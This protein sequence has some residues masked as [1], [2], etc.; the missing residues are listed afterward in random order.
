MG[1]GIFLV[2]NI[3]NLLLNLEDCTCFCCP[4][5]CPKVQAQMIF[6]ESL[7]FRNNNNPS[8]V[9]ASKKFKRKSVLQDRDSKGG[10]LS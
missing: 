5:P 8:Q 4:K 7:I 10:I 2:L 3:L 6:D 1:F 9:T